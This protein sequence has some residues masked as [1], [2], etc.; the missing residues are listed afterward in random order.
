MDTRLVS[1]RWSS[2][3]AALFCFER[4][5]NRT[6]LATL[7]ASDQRATARFD[8]DDVEGV[9]DVDVD[10]LDA[11]EGLGKFEDSFKD[12]SLKSTFSSSRGAAL[13]EA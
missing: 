13:P 5:A 3:S 12:S 11:A 4:L 6:T 9:E 7:K 8:K 1:W 2:S 10:L